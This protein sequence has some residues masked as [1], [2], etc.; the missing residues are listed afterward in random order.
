MKA[1]I[2]SCEAPGGKRQNLHEILPLK[3]PLLIQIFPIY[4][5]NF[6]C[7]Y[8]HFS[9]PKNKRGFVSNVL[10]M[11]MSLYKKCVDDI[12]EFPDK[13]KTF[14]FV[15]MGE[16]LLHKDIAQM[17]QYA[18]EANIADRI[19]ILTNGSLLSNTLSEKL[20][21]AGLSRLVVSIQGTTSD[22]YKATSNINLDINK[23]IENLRF[24]Y[25]HKP[26]TVSMYVKIV[27]T[28][29]TDEK[30]KELFYSL[31]GDVC[32][33]IG[34]EHTS[35]IYPGVDLNEELSSRHLTQFGLPVGSGNV[36]SQAFYSMQINPD[37][38]VVPCYSIVYPEIIGN[39]YEESLKNIWNGDKYNN[40]RINMLLGKLPTVC[41]EC[42]IN[43]Y[44]LFPEDDINAYKEDLLKLYA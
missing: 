22:K 13:V 35:P 2:I 20:I 37:G 33:S 11:E 28:A 32:D 6:K 9:I 8:C 23:L 14:R 43:R 5:C 44:R 31:F 25:E 12:K 18:K 4:R 40:F 34:V 30:E 7:V 42:N 29:L 38:N 26:K 15:G 19:E 16:P 21:K 1:K 36:C 41:K 3:T 17:V 27:D 39:C 10:D 24:F